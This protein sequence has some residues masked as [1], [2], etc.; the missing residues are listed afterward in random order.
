MLLP[1]IL[2]TSPIF[3]PMAKIPDD[4]PMLPSVFD[5]L[6]DLEPEKSVEPAKSRNQVLRELK[7]SV[8]RD[9]ENLLNTRWR[10]VKWPPDL[11]ELEVSVV[12]YG[13]PDFTGGRLGNVLDREQFRR[14]V[15]RLV[16]QFEP[17]FKSVAVK[18]LENA[19]KEDRMLRFRVDGLLHAEPA[20]E[21]VT[22]D[23][24][25]EPTTGNIQ[26]KG[27]TR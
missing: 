15:E 5:R 24:A 23:T 9:L 11:D 26:V 20:P 3:L 7:Q 6:I 13:I 4:Q 1:M 27:V 14:G 12:N 17:R 18:M 19:N 21:P 10:C 25:V 2:R 22:F 8:R 16:R